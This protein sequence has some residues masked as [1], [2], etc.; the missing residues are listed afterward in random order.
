MPRN[1]LPLEQLYPRR[2][3]AR[4]LAL[5]LDGYGLTPVAR[6]WNPDS[7]EELL[8]G[9][10]PDEYV[11]GDRIAEHLRRPAARVYL[12][13]ARARVIVEHLDD[14]LRPGH[15]KEFRPEEIGL[16]SQPGRPDLDIEVDLTNLIELEGALLRT[17]PQRLPPPNRPWTSPPRVIRALGR[18]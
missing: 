18:R 17:A 16:Y 12:D 6:R 1:P 11:I 3:A 9:A 4:A 7:P 8:P 14:V 2:L 15:R 5:A 10:D 13:G